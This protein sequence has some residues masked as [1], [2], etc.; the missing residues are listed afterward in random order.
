MN[1][2]RSK[3]EA[4]GCELMEKKTEMEM[5]ELNCIE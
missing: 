4:K 3:H 5:R 2:E 1:T